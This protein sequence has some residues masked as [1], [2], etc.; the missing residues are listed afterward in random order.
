[1]EGSKSQIKKCLSSY[2]NLSIYGKGSGNT[3]FMNEILI[4]IYNDLN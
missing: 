3:W 2:K 1:M 4:Q